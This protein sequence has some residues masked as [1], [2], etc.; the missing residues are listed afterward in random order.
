M[1]ICAVATCSMRSVW[2]AQLQ[3]LMLAKRPSPVNSWETDW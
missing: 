1:A 3:P 2:L